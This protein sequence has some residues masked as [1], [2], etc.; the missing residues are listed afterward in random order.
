MYYEDI[1]SDFLSYFEG[2]ETYC[3]SCEDYHNDKYCHVHAYLKFYE[4]IDFNDVRE[5]LSWFDGSV[6][7]QG[8]R[9]NNYE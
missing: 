1:R 3:V 5:V 6:N 7:V 4:L 9:S 2:V 8:P